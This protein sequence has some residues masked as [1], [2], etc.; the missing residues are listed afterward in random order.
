[1]KVYCNDCSHQQKQRIFSEMLT[2][3]ICLHPNGVTVH[4]TPFCVM[5]EYGLCT[6]R[7]A[8]NDCSD[9]EPVTNK[10]FLARLFCR[11]AK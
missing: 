6:D 5:E 4:D 10:S 11:I 7:N 8:I 1:M 2:T 3:G 9:F